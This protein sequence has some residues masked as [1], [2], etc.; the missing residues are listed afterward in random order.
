MRKILFILIIVLLLTGCGIVMYKGITGEYID[1]WGFVQ[2]QEEDNIINSRN[3]EL[4]TIVSV[5]FPSTMKK[6]NTTVETLQNTKEEYE[7]QAILLADSKYYRQTENYKLEFLWTKIGNYAKDNEVEIKIDVTNS[8]IKGLYDLNFSAVGRYSDVTQF[9]YDIEND[10]RLGFKIE[11]FNM[12][13]EPITSEVV[14]DNGEKM[15]NVI[16]AVRGT[17]AC[18]E[19]RIDIKSIDAST[20]EDTQSTEN[21]LINSTTTENTTNTIESEMTTNTIENTQTVE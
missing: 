1:I 21:S 16:S 15:T 18:K 4:S 3:D 9:I 14:M 20:T 17:F 19:I 8:Q 10:S 12:I 2:I 5:K 13:S 11:D 7:N 6:L